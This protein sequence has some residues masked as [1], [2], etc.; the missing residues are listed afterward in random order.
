[1]GFVTFLN[2][3]LVIIFRNKTALSLFCS[4]ETAYCIFVFVH[5]LPAGSTC[6]G[7]RQAIGQMPKHRRGA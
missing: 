7:D 3:L 6:E 4:C 2:I 1:M 5:L